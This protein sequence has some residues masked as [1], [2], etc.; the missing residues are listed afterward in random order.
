MW[1]RIVTTV[2]LQDMGPSARRPRTASKSATKT[3][4][5]VMSLTFAAVTCA[6]SGTPRAL[7]T[8]W[9]LDPALR[10]SVGFGPVF[11]PRA[12]RDRPAAHHRPA[13]VRAVPVGAARRGGSH[14]KR[15]QTPACCHS[16][17][18]RQHVLPEPHPISR[19][20]ICH[21]NPPR[22]TNRMP[23]NAGRSETRGRP[24]PRRARRRGFGSNGSRRAHSAS[25]KRGCAMRDRTKSTAQVQGISQR[26]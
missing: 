13:L 16:T 6:T 11:F 20:N 9:C 4:R 19:G 18:R 12:S 8:M 5:W 7:V 24:P 22:N 14:A 1:F 10:R 17:K 2:A 15:R 21:G 25:S 23:V 26:F 3:S